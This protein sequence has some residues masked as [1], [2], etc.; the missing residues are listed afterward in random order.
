[1]FGDKVLPGS[2]HLTARLCC[3]V[4]LVGV[5]SDGISHD[6]E[7]AQSTE[8]STKTFVAPKESNCSATVAVVF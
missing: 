6:F 8:Y 4:L 2:S 7:V 1:M 5:G 3:R